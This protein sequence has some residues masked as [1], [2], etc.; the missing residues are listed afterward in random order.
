RYVW[1]DGDVKELDMEKY[2]QF[3]MLSP[4]GTIINSQSDHDKDENSILE[5]DPSTDEEESFVISDNDHNE[6]PLAGME[7]I[8]KNH[9]HMYILKQTQ[10]AMTPRRFSGI[11]I[12]MNT[13]T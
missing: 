2:D 1:L 8:Y 10:S 13:R 6:Y 12:M 7:P 11:S 3:A 4:S 5:Y 9:G